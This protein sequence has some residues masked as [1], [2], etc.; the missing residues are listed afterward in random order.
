MQ[1]FVP[2]ILRHNNFLLSADRCIFWEDKK[3]LIVTDLHFG[4]TGH[5]RK[6][7]I[8]VPQTIFKEDIQRFVKLLQHYKPTTVV[9][10]GDMFHSYAN[11]EHH[12][13]L[14]WRKD[15]EQL[16]IQ[17]VMGNHDILQS[18]WYKEAGIEII[19]KQL[20]IDSFSF[21]HDLADATIE[22]INEKYF[23]SGHLHP[24]IVISGAAKQSL[25]F[26][27]FYFSKHFA[28][29]PAFSRFT[30]TQGIKPKRGENVFAI[31]P[32]GKNNSMQAG[33]LKVF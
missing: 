25:R 3:I 19:N 32:G 1:Q 8:A 9:V 5:F 29:L 33:I 28:V 12:L 15:F 26:P 2:Y 4:K 7:G 31:I 23:F 17:L 21:V 27:C 20:D 14:K 6:S 22:N 24:G 18:I 11:L 16:Q 30:G 10:I 13:F